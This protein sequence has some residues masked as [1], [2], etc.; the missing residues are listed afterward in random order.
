[1]N[2][3]MPDTSADVNSQQDRNG[4]L[5]GDQECGPMGDRLIIPENHS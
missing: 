3:S 4:E 2:L 5:V 1:M